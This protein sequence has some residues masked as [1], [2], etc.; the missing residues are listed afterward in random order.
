MDSDLRRRPIEQV[1]L[2]RIGDDGGPLLSHGQSETE[3]RAFDATC[4]KL[5]RFLT[6]PEISRGQPQ[7]THRS[8]EPNEPLTACMRPPGHAAR[9]QA[10]QP[11]SG[12]PKAQGLTAIR[13]AEAQLAVPPGAALPHPPGNPQFPPGNP[14]R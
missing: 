3:Q 2:S 1:V 6:D 5:S 4:R 12:A 11:R 7:N 10:P 14:K 9:G 13:V 8:D